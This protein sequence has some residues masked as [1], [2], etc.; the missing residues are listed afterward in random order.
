VVVA[1]TLQHGTAGVITPGP[2]VADVVEDSPAGMF[3]A[4]V[5]V[6]DADSGLNGQVNCTMVGGGT[7]FRLLQKYDTEYQVIPTTRF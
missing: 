5:S 6:T 3:V 4:H 1:S 7:A 2:A